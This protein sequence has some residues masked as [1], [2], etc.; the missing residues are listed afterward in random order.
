MVVKVLRDE[1]VLAH[2]FNPKR[3]VRE[4]KERRLIA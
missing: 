3:K 1:K 4:R 2:A